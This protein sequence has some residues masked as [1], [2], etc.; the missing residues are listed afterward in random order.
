MWE[1][2]VKMKGGVLLNDGKSR[3]R[4]RSSWVPTCKTKLMEGTKTGIAKER[5]E[6]CLQEVV[7]GS[8]RRKD[9][10]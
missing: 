7:R 6:M 3:G 9:Q 5:S 4:Q 8:L 2:K 10:E 1:V